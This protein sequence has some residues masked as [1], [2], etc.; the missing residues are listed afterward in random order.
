MVIREWWIGKYLEGSGRDLIL[1][2]YPGSNMERLSKTTK[3][4]QDSR[5]PGRGFNSCPP[6]YEAGA[7]NA[8]PQR[9]VFR[10]RKTRTRKCSYA[11]SRY[12]GGTQ[13]QNNSI[14]F[15]WV[16]CAYE[17]KCVCS[18]ENLGTCISFWSIRNCPDVLF[19]TLHAMIINR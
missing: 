5:S 13:C 16:V 11:V 12:F 6:K 10:Q 3:K 4:A 1:R 2:Y 14:R 15:V 19:T 17:I 8:R 7:L 9:S 18:L